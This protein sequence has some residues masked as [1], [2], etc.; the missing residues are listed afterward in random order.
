MRQMSAAF[1]LYAGASVGNYYP[2]RS[3]EP[4]NYLPDRAAWAEVGDG[5][6]EFEEAYK[7]FTGDDERTL[8][9]LGYAFYDEAS[10]HRVLDQLEKDPQAYRGG[11]T[12]LEKE[13]SLDP[14]SSEFDEL[15]PL[16]R[17]VGQRFSRTWFV[18]WGPGGGDPGFDNPIPVLW[19]MPREKGDRVPVLYLSGHVMFQ[20]YPGRFPMSPLFINRVRV[21]MGL[22]RD[23]EF[24]M[25]TPILPIVRELLEA[26]SR[27]PGPRAGSLLHLDVDPTVPAG[28][29][30]GYRIELTYSELVLFPE[31]AMS[32]PV[33]TNKFLK[34]EDDEYFGLPRERVVRYMGASRGYQW[35]GRTDYGVFVLLEKAF[36]LAGGDSLY[37]A[38]AS[39]WLDELPN[40]A[41]L[42]PFRP[43]ERGPEKILRRPSSLSTYVHAFLTKR[44]R[45]GNPIREESV[46][47]VAVLCGSVFWHPDV[48]GAA[49]APELIAVAMNRLIA[50]S[51]DDAEAVVTLA[52]SYVFPEPPKG[53]NRKLTAEKIA[54]LQRLPRGA[55]LSI[56][57]HLA[58]NLQ[59]EHEA[60]LCQKLLEELEA[61]PDGSTVEHGIILE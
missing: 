32:G 23:P 44:Q 61:T 20:E 7:L 56:V 16:R 27:E 38:A 24:S 37:D 4:D 13:R 1:E 52:L 47:A 42:E 53:G 46:Q 36:E 31:G 6:T 30:R 26:G 15:H 18:L 5:K 54:F 59:D 21:L 43:D 12:R 3:V 57:R 55:V 49:P 40:E 34:S 28:N 60:G 58:E 19:Q 39:Y 48:I 14:F 25:D 50:A 45:E 10:A 29:A 17:G 9:Y 35:Y 33:A 22:P 11:G 2:L 41:W 51:E 8:C